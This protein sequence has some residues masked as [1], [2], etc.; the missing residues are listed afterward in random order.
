V[1]GLGRSATDR[2]RVGRRLGSRVSEWSARVAGAFTVR[3]HV[4]LLEPRDQDPQD[5]LV[6]DETFYSD[7]VLPRFSVVKHGYDRDG[8]DGYV[9]E[10]EAALI[11]AQRELAELRSHIPTPSEI[12][13]ELERLGEQTSAILITAHQTATE[14]VSVAEAH[15]QICV[16]DSASYATALREEAH[17]ERRGV[18]LETES[19][20]RERDRLISSIEHTAA[21]LS[22]LAA[23]AVTH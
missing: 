9:D 12:T 19:L 18:E 17:Q 11:E 20:R 10:L 5:A 14:T 4:P 23:D 8:V 3:P 21:A 7:S 1:A 6:L 13:A 22:S 15:A 16:A 2:P